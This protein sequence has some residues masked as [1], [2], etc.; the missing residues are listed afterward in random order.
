MLY[1]PHG[2]GKTAFGANAPDPIFILTED[3]LGQIEANH[4]PVATTYQEVLDAVGTLVVEEHNFKTV[5]IDSLDWLENII[6]RD[7]EEKHDA[8]EL[9]Y[10]RGAVMAAEYWRNILEGLAVL[11]D[12]KGMSIIL[13]AHAE[14]KRF[15]S[16][17][18][19][20]FDR[21]QPK[22]Q[23][24]SSALIQEWCDCVF[25]CNYKTIVKKEDVGFNKTV[26]RG[27]TTGDRLIYTNE[28]PAY[29]AKNR[30]SLPDAIPLAWQAF[31][32]AIQ[33]TTKG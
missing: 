10:G 13:L 2:L 5:V 12:Q 15:D 9:A 23:A 7:L 17:E 33:P 1:G 21:Y 20:P 19:E 16:P 8:K 26:S 22:L 24:R 31:Q 27:I 28:K 4:F 32:E 29:Y 18:V 30:F 3:G 14:I 11:R 25:F 6:M